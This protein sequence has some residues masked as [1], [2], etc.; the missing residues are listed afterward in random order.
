MCYLRYAQG[1]VTTKNKHV[2]TVTTCIRDVLLEYT[3]SDSYYMITM[4]Y[5]NKQLRRGSY[6]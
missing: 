5:I 1:V 2:V 3:Y 6:Y 4:I